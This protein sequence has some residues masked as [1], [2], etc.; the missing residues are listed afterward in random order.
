MDANAQ[1]DT[2]QQLN[3][4]VEFIKNHEVTGDV[5]VQAG[6]IRPFTV[7]LRQAGVNFGSY[8]S[9]PTN[10]A[11]A[12]IVLQRGLV[13]GQVVIYLVQ[14]VWNVTV[15]KHKDQTRF[16]ALSGTNTTANRDRYAMDIEMLEFGGFP[17]RYEMAA[18]MDRDVATKRSQGRSWQE[19]NYNIQPGNFDA[20]IS[21][22]SRAH[23]DAYRQDFDDG[24]TTKGR[25]AHGI[26][27]LKKKF[28]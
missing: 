11:Q 7:E 27:V 22:V 26:N 9:V 24:F 6:K 25:I 20:Y 16:A 8:L 4:V 21:F 5:W 18:A 3:E 13:V 23:T 19:Y 28:S 12:T 10:G 2:D 1:L 15:I 17:Y 14:E